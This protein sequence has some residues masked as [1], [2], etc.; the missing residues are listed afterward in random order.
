M[1]A[2][3][4]ILI[5]LAALILEA[6]DRIKVACVGNSITEGDYNYSSYLQKEKR[7]DRCCG[8]RKN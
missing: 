5:F 3:S 6:A 7:T 4:I 1:K 2:E 8:V